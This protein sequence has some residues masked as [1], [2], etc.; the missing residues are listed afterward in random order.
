MKKTGKLLL[1]SVMC[2]LLATAFVACSGQSYKLS[3]ETGC[4]ITVNAVEAKS[5]EEV[6]LPV[7]ERA[8][9]AFCGWYEESDFSGS[10]IEKIKPSRDTTFYAKWA[11][12]YSLT[13]DTAGGTLSEKTL[14]LKAGDNLSAVLRDKIPEKQNLV[15]GGW[16]IGKK[17]V[18]EQSV[19]PQSDLTVVAKYKAEYTVEL[20]RRKTETDEF[21]KYDTEKGYAYVGESFTSDDEKE[22]FTEVTTDETKTTIESVSEDSKNNVLKRFFEV[23][24][25][26]LTF[27]PGYEGSLS[28]SEQITL[29]YGDEYEF[30][31]VAF[32][33]KGYMLVGWKSDTDG[34]IYSVKRVVFNDEK[35]SVNG[36]KTTVKHDDV[37]TAV[38]SKGYSNAFGGDDYI[39]LFEEQPK[40]AY[41]VRGGLVFKGDYV[42]SRKEFYFEDENEDIIIEG[43]INDDYTFS[44]KVTNLTDVSAMLYSVENGVEKNTKIVFGNND[45]IIYTD[46][47][48]SSEG[49]YRVDENNLYTATLTSGDLKGQSLVFV[50]SSYS[51]ENEDTGA[52]EDVTVFRLRNEKEYELGTVLRASVSDGKLVYYPNAYSLTFGGFGTVVYAGVRNGV[53]STESFYCVVDGDKIILK[54]SDDALVGT[55]KTFTIGNAKC[56]MFYDEELDGSFTNENGVTLTLDGLYT[57]KYVANKTTVNGVYEISNSVFGGK[58]ITM[59]GENGVYKFVLDK[60]VASGGV[61]G[62]END[63]EETTYTLNIKGEDYREYYY[64]SGKTVYYA[65]LFVLGDKG[66]GT[67]SLYGYTQKSTFALISSGTYQTN[68]ISKKTTYTA[69]YFADDESVADVLNS[70]FNIKNI[71]SFDCFLSSFS[72]GSVNYPVSFWFSYEKGDDKTTLY[73]EYSSAD[74]EKLEVVGNVAYYRA[75]DFSAT[76]SFEKDGEAFVLT[77]SDGTAKKLYFACNEERLTFAR[78]DDMPYVAY[79]RDNSGATVKSKYLESDG[80]GGGKYYDNDTVVIGTIEK[81]NRISVYA[82]N[83]YSFK[84][85][86]GTVSFEFVRVSGS[87]SVYDKAYDKAYFSDKDGVLVLD[88]FGN[89][90]YTVL[91]ETIYQ[92][93]CSLTGTVVTAEIN[94]KT[95]YFDLTAQKFTLR[96]TEYGEYTVIDNNY[97]PYKEFYELDGYGVIKS[98]TVNADGVIAYGIQGE[99][100]VDGGR[101]F[102][103]LKNGA[104]KTEGEFEIGSGTITYKEKRY[105]VFITVHKEK[106]SV[107][108]NTNDWSILILD[109]VGGAVRISE[110]GKT[111]YGG[112]TLVTDNL[113][114]FFISD[115]SDACIFRY[116]YDKG[117]AIPVKF[118]NRGYYTTELESLL[119]S[120]YGFA[121]FGGTERCYYDLEGNDVIIYRKDETASGSKYGFRKEN[122]G[123]FENQKTYNGK[124]YYSNNGYA[125]K[126][127]RAEEGKDKY[128]VTLASGSSKKYSLSNLSF[129]P[130]GKK[131]F[132]ADAVITIN[133]RGY[134]A[135]VRREVDDE[136]NTRTYLDVGTYT[137]EIILDYKGENEPG[138]VTEGISTYT[139]I[140]MNSVIS[141]SAYR[142]LDNYYKAYVANGAKYAAGYKNDIGT[143]YV[144]SVYDEN[145]EK[146]DSYVSATFGSGSG[147]YDANG[148]VITLE[149]AAFV[150]DEESSTYIVNFTANDGFNY[151]FAFGLRYHSAYKKTFGYYVYYLVRTETLDTDDGYEVTAKRIIASDYSNLSSGSFHSVTLKKDGVE[152][153]Y[154]GAIISGDKTELRY[155]TRE[156]D[157]FGTVISSTYYTIKFVNASG[158]EI[159]DNDKV[160][161]TYASVHVE[162]KEMIVLNTAD[163]KTSIDAESLTNAVLLTTENGV[164]LVSSTAYDETTGVYTIVAGGKTYAFKLSSD[165]KTIVDFSE[166]SEQ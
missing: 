35:A 113:L 46:E 112:Y 75:A 142:Y 114:Y 27:V 84:S 131:E 156:K 147:F 79:L 144:N 13:L 129:A 153:P 58:I 132:K 60:K 64:G 44:Y 158:A 133:G 155:I 100:V 31:A 78:L 17:S 150:Y 141:A 87:F 96:G 103:T 69:T 18:S 66:V 53:V 26:D 152:I 21:E 120:E 135:Y 143:V 124:T 111:D 32:E 110:D 40:T 34:K 23:K 136:N 55:V 77:Y 86:D 62:D 52:V 128:P 165:G 108:V 76:G 24:K 104:E 41:F 59:T 28:R 82:G 45:K 148:D 92:G 1:I 50:L 16:F 90:S 95:R 88:G 91:G 105:N 48:G 11:K 137:F 98:F 97:A 159:G 7:L 116:D 65:P 101:V 154:H 138:S 123:A 72:S 67:A 157:E 3:F 42:A 2:L 121:I 94:G 49:Y 61:I 70:P 12:L 119:F 73:V 161:A 89:C 8:G 118:S 115:G 102:F 19:M 145:G 56:Y 15:F 20:F 117:T 107:Y 126:F 14:S 22:G 99:Y 30:S 63:A 38:W 164:A 122:F 83:V 139:V 130:D 160:P 127:V 162:R 81:T 29:R 68:E 85:G 37:F 33:R 80:K 25:I 134:I 125:V 149:R 5:G 57:A 71:H 43:K 36:D 9:Y 151:E 47:N 10:P 51:A 146:T 4:E 163:G 54:N 140:S 106:V 166:T 74:G 39:Y 93:V 109:D 6:S